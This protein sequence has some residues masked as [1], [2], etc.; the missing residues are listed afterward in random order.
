MTDDKKEDKINSIKK[1]TENNVAEKEEDDVEMND[2]E[3]NA[4][5]KPVIESKKGEITT[6][7]TTTIEK[8]SE[9]EKM[10]VDGAV[11]SS[12]IAVET[13]EKE[14]QPPVV[15]EPKAETPKEKESIAETVDNTP[16]EPVAASVTVAVVTPTKVVEEEIKPI[17]VASPVKQAAPAVVEPVKDKSAEENCSG[18]KPAEGEKTETPACK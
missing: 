8:K 1:V 11:S 17:V 15:N 18:V 7:T 13:V 3:A 5:D 6:E 9:V 2:V 16:N 4:T 10:E 12:A 14:H